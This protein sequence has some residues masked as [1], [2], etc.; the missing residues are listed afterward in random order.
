MVLST[1]IKPL[2]SLERRLRFKP[3]HDQLE[4]RFE[5]NAENLAHEARL[6]GFRPGKVPRSLIQERYRDT[7]LEKVHSHGVRDAMEYAEQLADFDVWK[8]THV[9]IDKPKDLNDTEYIVDFIERPVLDFSRLESLDLCIPKIE[10]DED[11]VKRGA[12]LYRF[13]HAIGVE[14]DRPIKHGDRVTLE[15]EDIDSRFAG[16]VR[17]TYAEWAHD[18]VGQHRFVM[19]KWLYDADQLGSLLHDELL[20]RSVGDE[21]EVEKDVPSVPPSTIQNQEDAA[22]EEVSSSI[23]NIEGTDNLTTAS[24]EENEP[25]ESE[26][27]IS[28]F[29]WLDPARLPQ[30]QLHVKVKILHVEEISASAVAEEFFSRN[31]VPYTNLIELNEELKRYTSTTAQQGTRDAQIAQITAQICALNPVD[32]PYRLLVGEQHVAHA[33]KSWTELGATFLPD[34]FGV[35]PSIFNRGYFRILEFL[36]TTQYAENN[37]LEPTD[38]LITEFTRIEYE[39]L[40]KLGQDSDR[41]FDPE[42][43]NL[44]RHDLRRTRVVTD[45]YERNG[46]PEVSVSFFDFCF[47]SR[48]GF[49]TLPPT[50]GP[51]S[52]SAP[53]STDEIEQTLEVETRINSPESDVS[54]DMLESSGALDTTEEAHDSPARGNVFTNWFKKKFKSSASTKKE[55]DIVTEEQQKQ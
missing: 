4:R 24:S 40:S 30:R 1:S 12:T 15:I 53:V 44:V 28:I 9:D 27:P 34:F 2:S 37:D 43:Q 51:F 6:P 8:I 25:N 23:N 5:Q 36:Y 7:I 13:D 10:I 55:N 46:A 22:N 32:L 41:V 17:S 52:W 21:F 38:D 31:D 48:L 50:G 33:D 18:Y 42:Y 49:W 29:S 39:R 45:I 20:N 54:K 26:S 14:L 16:D 11:C 3:G 47:L 35:K 19:E